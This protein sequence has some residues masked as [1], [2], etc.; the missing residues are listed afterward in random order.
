LI[1]TGDEVLDYRVALN[2]YEEAELT[3]IEGGNH[4]LK[5]FPQFIPE[6][7]RRSTENKKSVAV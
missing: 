2:T 7:I 4:G 3:V 6:I 1:E 5:S